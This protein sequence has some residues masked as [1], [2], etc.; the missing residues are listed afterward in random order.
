MT[1]SSAEHAYLV[2]T[3]VAVPLVNPKHPDHEETRARVGTRRLGLAG[4]AAFET[5]AVLSRLPAPLRVPP[6]TT[7]VLL[8]RAFPATVHLSAERSAELLT[9]APIRGIAGGSVYDALVGAAALEHGMTLLSRDRRARGTYAAL[10]V[11]V[12]Y[13][14]P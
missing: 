1:T 13:L 5:Y 7:L 6:A 10:G 9:T 14:G 2:D 11:D 12:E 4:H 3:S 8:Q